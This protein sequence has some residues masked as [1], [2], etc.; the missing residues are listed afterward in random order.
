MEDLFVATGSRTGPHY[1]VAANCIHVR[2]IQP[3]SL[4]S[5]DIYRAGGRVLG[6]RARSVLYL[7]LYIINLPS[8]ILQ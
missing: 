3:V 6:E 2:V 8:Y 7:D 5:N 1:G 4:L